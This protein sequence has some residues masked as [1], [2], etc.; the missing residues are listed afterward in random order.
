MGR[1]R[2]YEEGPARY[3]LVLS[4]ADK[5]IL[6]SYA[7]YV[8]YVRNKNIAVAEILLEALRESPEFKKFE[9]T[10][11]AAGPLFSQ[12]V[13]PEPVQAPP[14]TPRPKAPPV[15]VVALRPLPTQEE[16]P[17]A[18]DMEIDQLRAALKALGISGSEIARRADVHKSDVARF[19]KGERT[20]GPG[21]LAKLA[22]VLAAG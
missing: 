18:Q 2:K 17:S 5:A 13:I 21:S 6:E 8:S 11:R 14:V 7:R 9:K 15:P 1:P 22:G 4:P 12:E 20:L 3:T 19:L 16:A 10:G